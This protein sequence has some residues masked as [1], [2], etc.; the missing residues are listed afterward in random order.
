VASP[1]LANIPS[2]E[3][4]STTK[5]SR[6]RPEID[7][8][9]AFAVIAVIINHFNKDILPSGYLG[10]DIFFVISGF[11]ITSSLL[12]RE[13]KNFGDFLSGFYERRIKR[14][15]PAL[16]VFVLATSLLICLFNP[17]PQLA[18]RTGI[19]SL[20]GL[21]NL[22]LLRQSTDYFAEATELN[23]FVHTWSLGVEE[24][25]YLLFPFLI[26]FSGFGRQTAR[27]ARNLFWT[28]GTLSIASVIS[29]IYLSQVNQP[30]S[31][32][33]MPPRFWE[34]SAGCLVFLALH[35]RAWISDYL[36]KIPPLLIGIAIIG[37]LF[38]PVSFAVPATF[39]MVILTGL[40]IG[41][42]RQ[43]NIVF[44]FLTL[45]KVV[46]IGLIS[47]SL[48][49]WHWGVLSI[50][51]WTIGI[52]W[53]SVPIQLGLMFLIAIVSY[54]FIETPLRTRRWFNQRIV[55][56]GSGIAMVL[57]LSGFLTASVRAG[58]YSLLY[59]GNLETNITKPKDYAGNVT[60][61]KASNCHTSDGIKN[62]SLK[63]SM[64]LTKEFVDNCL[65]NSS[66]NSSPLL[67]FV[68]DS[69]TL[70]MFPMGE[71]FAKT[72]SNS[73]FSLSRDGC[74]FP[75]QGK[76]SRKGCNEIMKEA[77]NFLLREIKLR[78]SG[79]VVVATSYLNS[80]FGY[81]GDH[82]K[83]FLAN[84]SGTHE[85]VNANLRL[86]MQS[87]ARLADKIAPYGGKIV[88]VAPLPEH[89]LFQPESCTKQWFK[90]AWSISRTCYSTNKQDLLD[91]RIH[92]MKEL[93]KLES[94]HS[95]LHVYDAFQVLC[96]GDRCKNMS[97]GQFLY[98]DDDH[99]SEKGIDY[100]FDDFN[101]F[102]TSKRAL[103]K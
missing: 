63:G 80:H 5:L 33:L 26:W 19:A 84:S 89:P 43:G 4:Q 73:I 15:V 40:L 42:L 27:G 64:V 55:S 30:A 10:V 60:G 98:S 81:N 41:S 87:M 99:L 51:R 58:Y 13:S 101:S 66:N 90:P 88:V 93:T 71:K 1:Q 37:V 3:N 24:Q 85:D 83:Q 31:Y 65:W 29:Y 53:W 25:F 34:M 72:N 91:K 75:S 100:I 48:Y 86:Y 47:Y 92:I 16:V 94:T 79:S 96:K 12:G 36:Q 68:G 57:A 14:L 50:S 54:R 28:V 17:N 8:L 9:R 20:F 35:R 23:P 44:N 56:I 69:H 49:L 76:T 103:A 46:Y 59:A 61:R 102:L 67:A 2:K 38:L 22:Y 11:V 95:N 62:D 7:G 21:S 6:Y 77:E 45:D 18:L 70:S 52:H 97:A 74:S 39:S 78:D 32:F 82:R